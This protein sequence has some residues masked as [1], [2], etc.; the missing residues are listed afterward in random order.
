MHITRYGHA[1]LLIE[2]DGTRLFVDPG[3]FCGDHVFELTQLDAILITHEHFDHCDPARVGALLEANPAT[4]VYAPASVIAMLELTDGRGRPV[5]PGQ[6]IA[7]GAITAEPVGTTHQQILPTIPRCANSG[8]VFTGPDDTRLFHPGDS[9]ETIPDDIDV[10]AVPMHAPWGKITETATFVQAVAPARMFPIHDGFL[11][12]S[13]RAL[14]WRLLTGAIGSEV[15]LLT[16][17]EG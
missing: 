14:Y 15:K 12:D 16:P 7:C 1:A 13:G 4:P 3:S 2:A 6:S 17:S 11:Q 8:F 5:T 9:Y 10:L